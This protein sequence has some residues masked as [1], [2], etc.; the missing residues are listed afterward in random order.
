MAFTQK[1]CE[2]FVAVCATT[3]VGQIVQIVLIN[4]DYKLF[5]SCIRNCLPAVAHEPLLIPKGDKFCEVR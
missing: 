1:L 3:G 4:V 5:I 2:V